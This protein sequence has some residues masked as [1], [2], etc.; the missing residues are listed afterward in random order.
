[1]TGLLDYLKMDNKNPAAKA[2]LWHL[3]L[4]GTALALETLNLLLRG[5]PGL[6]KAPLLAATGVS[7]G[8]AL[9]LGIGGW[10]GGELV[11]KH[12]VGIAP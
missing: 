12:R 5:G 6:P 7:L 3:S 8:G 9:L 4:M 10:W 11:Y 1:M 2:A